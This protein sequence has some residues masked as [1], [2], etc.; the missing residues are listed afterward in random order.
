M[1]LYQFT[2][3]NS[4]IQILL[5]GCFF[6]SLRSSMDALKLFFIMF[7]LLLCLFQPKSIFIPQET[8]SSEND[9]QGTIKRCPT[10]ESP[11]KSAS[12]VPPRPP[13]PRLP[14]QKSNALGNKSDTKKYTNIS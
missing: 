8:H 6:F 9:S 3:E 10:S 14:P 7:L 11:A 4:R 2:G 13:P 5:V 12:Q 1:L